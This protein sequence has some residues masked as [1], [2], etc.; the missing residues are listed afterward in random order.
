MSATTE[1][2]IV[3][4][5][6]QEGPKILKR[7]D[8]YYMVLAEG[9][10]AGPPTGQMIVSARSKSIEGQWENS[11]HNPIVRT[12]SPDEP[13]W[14]KG[15]GTLV[16][17]PDGKWW[18]VYHAYERGFLTLGRQTLLQAIEWTSD[19][20]F[21]VTGDPARPQ[22]LPAKSSGPHGVAFSDDSSTNRMGTHWGCYK[23]T[24]TDRECYRYEN[25]TR[26][27]TTTSRTSSSA[28]ARRSM[29][30]GRERYGSGTS[31][32]GRLSRCKVQGARCRVQG[33]RRRVQ[34]ARCRVQGARL[35][36]CTCT[37]APAPLHLH[38]CTCP[39]LF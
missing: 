7:V 29:R 3:E 6:A 24:T 38:P 1:D 33:A 28:C 17:A 25:G 39:P 13:W 2:W 31:R 18:M 4:G 8:Y 9:G 34:G 37:L 30:R 15:H 5:F 23:G 32:T 36:C 10:T 22:P 35:H 11:P 26:G 27:I 12:Q 19:A 14:S 16:E 20:W 21:R